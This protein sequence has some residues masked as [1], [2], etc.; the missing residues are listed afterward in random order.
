MYENV[1]DK[2]IRC[3]THTYNAPRTTQHIRAQ[4]RLVLRQLEV[5]CIGRLNVLM[6]YTYNWTIL[7]SVLLQILMYAD[8]TPYVLKTMRLK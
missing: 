6:T 3:V 1:C 8:K 4:E 7:G 5:F 2:K